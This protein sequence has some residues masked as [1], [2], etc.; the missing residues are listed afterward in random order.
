M[1]WGSPVKDVMPSEY[2]IDG[3]TE[4]ELMKLAMQ[5]SKESMKKEH[6][7]FLQILNS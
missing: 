7:K 6:G 3:L 5:A 1:P 2:N 4:D